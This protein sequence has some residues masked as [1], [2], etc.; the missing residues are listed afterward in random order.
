MVGFPVDIVDVEYA[1]RG[2][3]GCWR[4]DTGPVH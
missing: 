3:Q 4:N 1:R 2:R